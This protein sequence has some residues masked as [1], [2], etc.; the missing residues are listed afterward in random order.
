MHI[1]TNSFTYTH[2]YITVNV[3]VLTCVHSRL[4][5]CVGCSS[6]PR[7]STEDVLQQ[8]YVVHMYTLDKVQA[9]EQ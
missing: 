4:S 8:S 3:H 6:H 7:L 1:F 9:E 5:T 2:S